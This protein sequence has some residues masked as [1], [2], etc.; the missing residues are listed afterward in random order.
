[1]LAT[2]YPGAKPEA[3]ERREYAS[4]PEYDAKLA[5]E[6]EAVVVP[7]TACLRCHDVPANGKRGAFESIPPLAFDPLDKAGREA[8]ARTANKVRKREVLSRLQARL[9]K[10]VDMPPHDSPEHEKFPVKGAAFED[11]KRFLDAEL[12]PVPQP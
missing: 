7:T 4:G 10:D 9:Y 3:V 11:L 8:W 2:K 12:P 1:M 5:T 6:A